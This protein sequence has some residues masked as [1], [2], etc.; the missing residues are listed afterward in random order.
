M[1]SEAVQENKNERIHGLRAKDREQVKLGAEAALFEQ[2][3]EILDE[4]AS[5]LADG[6]VKG[7][8]LESLE[9][10]EQVEAP[11][12]RTESTTNSKELT[13]AAGSPEG[14]PHHTTTPAERPDEDAPSA[15]RSAGEQSAHPTPEQSANSDLAVHEESHTEINAPLAKANITATG[16][17]VVPTGTPP[18]EA[19]AIPAAPAVVSKP[20]LGG[21]E[22]EAITSAEVAEVLESKLNA[23]TSEGPA[24][25]TP[26]ESAPR[27]AGQAAKGS[28]K[29]IISPAASATGNTAGLTPEQ[30]LA[31][32]S[33]TDEV[34]A[35]G[36]ERERAAQVIGTAPAAAPL[37]KSGPA[38]T[39]L[40]ISG[41]V[42]ARVGSDA[43]SAVRPELSK[44]VSAIQSG[45]STQSFNPALSRP[46]VDAARR[47][48][49]T[50]SAAKLFT[51]PVALRTLE[52]VEAALQEVARSRDGKTISIK[53]DPG[54]LGQ[55]KVDVS[56]RDGHL[57]ARIAA[58]S[59]EVSAWLREHA[60]E[61]QS[62]LRKL[63]LAVDRVTV[64]VQGEGATMTG[65]YSHGRSNGSSSE[66][67]FGGL[68]KEER[69]GEARV[70]TAA[71]APVELDHWVA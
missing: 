61:L 35:A 54:Q 38:G 9:V 41:Q 46:V 21:S 22:D 58:E 12:P 45:G 24:A 33:I 10:I 20:A 44:A 69:R 56:I 11:S 18:G 28:A 70:P 31:A 6:R 71:P 40:D 67:S 34:K 62:T 37:L 25:Q 68:L 23:S 29:E 32:G 42:T 7:Q 55:V 52:K 16:E 39:T 14:V 15:A 65:E 47:E 60:P 49:E 50:Q 64:A 59:P 2:F 13:S 4:I 3:S 51:R 5:Q 17:E 30:S 1:K 63:G 43:G 48:Q 53:L 19:E 57:H 36:S 8:G 26:G 66:G 27:W